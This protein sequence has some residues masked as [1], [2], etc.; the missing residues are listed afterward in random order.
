MTL[1]SANPHPAPLLITPR[2]LYPHSLPLWVDSMLP[3]SET[4]SA[5]YYGKDTGYERRVAEVKVGYSC[6][7]SKCIYSTLIEYIE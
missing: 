6:D 5:K 7:C 1:K 2:A 3:V 4:L